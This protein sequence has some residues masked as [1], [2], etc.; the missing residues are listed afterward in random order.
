MFRDSGIN[1]AYINDHYTVFVTVEH[2]RNNDRIKSTTVKLGKFSDVCMTSFEIK[3]N[4][5][6]WEEFFF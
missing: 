4:V 2:E 6:H 3:L 1:C 5:I